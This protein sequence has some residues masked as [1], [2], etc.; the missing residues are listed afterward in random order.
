[1]SLILEDR[2]LAINPNPRV[3]ICI[4]LDTSAS[5]TGNKIYPL[6]IS[7]EHYV[8][9][10]TMMSLKIAENIIKASNCIKP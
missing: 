2:E 4:A 8:D 6:F 10:D 9:I 1:M 3:P 5:M 7:I